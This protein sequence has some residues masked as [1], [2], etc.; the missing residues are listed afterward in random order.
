MFKRSVAQKNSYVRVF[1][2]HRLDRA[3]TFWNNIIRFCIIKFMAKFLTSQEIQRIMN[4]RK[5]GHS[6]NEIRL[7]TRHA[8][9]TIHK[10]CRNVEISPGYR[11]ILRRK[12]G[13]GERRAQKAWQIAKI[14]ASRI[15]KKLS[16]RDHFLILA[17]LYWGE[18]TKHEL[19]FCNSDPEMIVIFARCLFLLGITRKDLLVTI[20][21][22]EDID[23]QKAI[24]FWAKLLEI[25]VSSIRNVNVLQ[26][27]KV[28]KLKYGMCRIRVAKSA[29]YFKLIMSLISEIK[30]KSSTLP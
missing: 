21:I 14:E 9:A 28:G 23:R 25:P 27:R 7:M 10:Y 3:I 11:E 5:T 6:V 16:R 8:G 19:N 18:G 13:G 17:A 12:Q 20:R 15:V 1:L 4:L 26:G 29:K 2:S 22:Y 30:F 24:E